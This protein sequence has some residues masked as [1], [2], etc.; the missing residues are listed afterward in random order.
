MVIWKSKVCKTADE[1]DG[2][3]VNAAT[4]RPAQQDNESNDNIWIE[5]S[6]QRNYSGGGSL[7][8]IVMCLNYIYF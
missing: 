4:K 7:C 3:A 1:E 6:N 2:C 8:I 5:P